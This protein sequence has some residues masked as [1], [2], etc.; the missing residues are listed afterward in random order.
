[1]SDPTMGTPRDPFAGV[2]VAIDGELVPSSS[3]LVPVFDRS[4]QL[5]DG[6]FEVLRAYAGHAFALDAHLARLERSLA[7]L[8]I[9]HDVAPLGDAVRKLV[10]RLAR[11]DEHPPDAYVRVLVSRGDALGLDPRGATRSRSVVVAAPVAPLPPLVRR[12][13]TTCSVELARAGEGSAL[14]RAKSTSYG[15]SVHALTEARAAGAS[16]AILTGATGELR[17]GHASNL[18]LVRAG[19]LV[20]P[21]LSLGIL[22]GITREVVFGLGRELGLAVREQLVFPSDV[23]RADEMFLTSSMRELVPVVSHDRWT[24]GVGGVGPITERLADG[25]SS[26]VAAARLAERQ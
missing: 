9:E 20:T 18:F 26:R 24:V 3:A 14:S 12:A 16:E 17:E 4:F 15:A 21:P 11:D 13:I 10:S 23:R 6:V 25:Y 1:M 8:A 2:L 7:T 5:G 19:E 22:G